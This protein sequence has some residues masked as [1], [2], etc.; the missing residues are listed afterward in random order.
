MYQ[1]VIDAFGPTPRQQPLLDGPA[2]RLDAL[3]FGS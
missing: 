2:E 1:R 3:L